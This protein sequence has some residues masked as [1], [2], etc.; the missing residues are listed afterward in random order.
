MDLHGVTGKP[1]STPQVRKKLPAPFNRN[2]IDL[3]GGRRVQRS[4]QDLSVLKVKPGDT[5]AGFGTVSEVVEFINIPESHS[6]DASSWRV[7]L[8]NVMGDWKDY[9]GEQR[10]FAFAPEPE[11]TT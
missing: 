3:D 2:R 6:P 11:V 10:V 1:Y 5:V 9:P 7:R 8:Y 4:W